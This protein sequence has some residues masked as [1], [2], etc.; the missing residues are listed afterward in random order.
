MFRRLAL[1]LG[2]LASLVVAAPA[3]AAPG[4]LKV[5]VTSNGSGYAEAV[6]A[7]VATQ[8]GVASAG[9]SYTNAATP[10]AADLAG[11]D[12]IVSIGD[13]NY[14]DQALWGD[15]LADFVDA[16][17]AVLQTAY[18][19]WDSGR[20]HPAGR[21]ETGGYAPLL[22]GNNDNTS[23]TLG[24]IVI[25]NHPLLEGLG[26]FPN[27][28]NTTTPLAPGATLVA[29]WSDGRNAIA[30]KGR[31]ASTSASVDE[32]TARPDIARLARNTGVFLGR[33][34]VIVSR[35]GTG[36][37]SVASTPAGIACGATCSMVLP[38]GGSATLS[39]T[40]AADSVFKGWSGACT[41]TAAC[42]PTVAGADLNVGAIFDKA[43]FGKKTNV[44]LK[45][46]STKVSSSGRFKI[47]ARSS[48]KFTVKGTLRASKVKSKKFTLKARGS[49]TVT[50]TL[51]KALREKLMMN[52]KLKLT[53]T[54]TV[55]DPAGKSRK[56]KKR[57]TLRPKS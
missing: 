19:N 3:Q 49:K 18:D 38:F 57:L 33:H 23:V 36:K 52:G 55:K 1:C 46:L 29:K 28:D 11:Y 43:T 16:G 15:R 53:V 20:A 42:V 4:A 14:Q 8:P 27:G 54:A 35:T 44:S 25:P 51:S 5:L 6:A 26:T 45:A 56:V 50:L 30:F 22:N 2:V 10:S 31:V 9:F 7:I 37:G 24:E 17:G 12:V 13:S 34:N 41:G 21:W 48:N 32:E 40:P 39:A 47:R